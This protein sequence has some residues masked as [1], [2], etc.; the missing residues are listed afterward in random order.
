MPGL[1]GALSHHPRP[2]G[3]GSS[4]AS[5]APGSR[6]PAAPAAPALWLG[7]GGEAGGRRGRVAGA[8]GRAVPLTRAQSGGGGWRSPAVHRAGEGAG[9]GG[10]AVPAG[11]RG[12]LGRRPRCGDGAAPQQRRDAGRVFGCSPGSARNASQIKVQPK[13][14]RSPVLGNGGHGCDLPREKGARGLRGRRG[15]GLVRALGVRGLPPLPGSRRAGRGPPAAGPGSPRIRRS[16]SP[17]PGAT[18]QD[19]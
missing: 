2:A 4:A 12:A 5:P 13:V 16:P 8:G 6:L 19:P 10:E 1:R 7:L 15:R 14:R 9:G 18:L 11:A 17:S 3:A